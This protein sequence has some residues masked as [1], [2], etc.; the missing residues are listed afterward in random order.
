[1][2]E[3]TLKPP[4]LGVDEDGDLTVKL[5]ITDVEILRTLVYERLDELDV[6]GISR[7][8]AFRKMLMKLETDLETMS[9]VWKE[10]QQ[11]T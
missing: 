10:S 8:S 2:K 6:E 5:H 3:I 1:M 7:H 9:T 11:T 4:V